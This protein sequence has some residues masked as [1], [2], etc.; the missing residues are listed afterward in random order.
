MFTSEGIQ[1]LASAM[2]TD[3]RTGQM[4][5]RA[6]DRRGSNMS[7]RCRQWLALSFARDEFVCRRGVTCHYYR[8]NETTTKFPSVPGVH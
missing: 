1:N 5:R 8:R 7:L 3:G 2:G 6:T 4:D